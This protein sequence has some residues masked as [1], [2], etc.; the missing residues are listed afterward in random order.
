MPQPCDLLAFG[1]HPDDV[2]LTCGGTLV[3]ATKQGYRTGS[4]DRTKGE[5]ATRGTPETR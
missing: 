4:V 3:K 2:E 5:T 1:A